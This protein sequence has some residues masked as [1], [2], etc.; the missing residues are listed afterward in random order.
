MNNMKRY[1]AYRIRL[2]KHKQKTWK[3]F[4]LSNLLIFLAAVVRY[5][6]RT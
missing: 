1:C 3:L 4:V 6:E 2:E 5:F